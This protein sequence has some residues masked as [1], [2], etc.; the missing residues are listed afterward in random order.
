MTINRLA[1]AALAAASF[2]A[3]ADAATVVVNHVYDP[4]NIVVSNIAGELLV[5]PF[6]LEAGDTLDITMTFTGGVSVSF[7]GEDGLWL[8]ALLIGN[9]LAADLE[10]TGTLEF[11]GASANIV[12][13]PIPQSQTNSE[14]HIGSYYG[15][16]LYRLDAA[17]ISFTG[18][19]QIITIDSDNIGEPREYVTVALTYFEGSGGGGDVVPEPATWAMLIAG[20]GLVGSALRR[21]RPLAA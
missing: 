6:T 21:R 17:E 8:L 19:R 4:A 18:L 15:S 3:S 2:A 5:D 1:I 14:A 11:L 20:F 12:S 7:T 13:G 10:T 16:S 9:G